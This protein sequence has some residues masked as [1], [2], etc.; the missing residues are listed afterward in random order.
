MTYPL[1]AQLALTFHLRQ[2]ILKNRL[3]HVD[4]RENVGDQT[5]G[6]G[7]GE[8]ADRPGAKQ[9]EEKRRN[10]RRHVRVNDRQE[11]FVKTSVDRRGG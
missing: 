9:E 11:R 4:R 7:N 1:N 6:Q 5:D 3:G 8:P 2:V 10:D